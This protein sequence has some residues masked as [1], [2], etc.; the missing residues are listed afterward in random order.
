MA[1]K[2]ISELD[3]ATSLTGAEILPIVQSGANKKSTLILALENVL[4]KVV[5][6]TSSIFV[7]KIS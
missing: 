3:A 5:T 2:K 4:K 6:N 1:T 7:V